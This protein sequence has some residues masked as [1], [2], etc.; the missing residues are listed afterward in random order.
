MSELDD[1]LIE[2][3]SW[4]QT[5][6]VEEIKVLQEKVSLLHNKHLQT[7]KSFSTG[8]RVPGD[9]TRS[10]TK[11]VTPRVAAFEVNDPANMARNESNFSFNYNAQRSLLYE[12]LE[13]LR[14][15]VAQFA[16]SYS[17]ATQSRDVQF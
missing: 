12:E 17:R 9:V 5:L 10:K 2:L 4:I 11:Q 15:Q 7:P 3:Q 13:I 16:D 1:K 6:R 8:L 14:D